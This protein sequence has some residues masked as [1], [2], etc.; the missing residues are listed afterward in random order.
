MQ[1]TALQASERLDQISQKL[2]VPEF[3]AICGIAETSLSKRKSHLPPLNFAFDFSEK[4]CNLADILETPDFPN[5]ENHYTKVFSFSNPAV[6]LGFKAAV[7]HSVKY[8]KDEKD[9]LYDVPEDDLHF[10]REYAFL[11][12]L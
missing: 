9:Q 3:H 12:F 1:I 5:D 10:F 4:I 11:A 7:A 2:M 8:L 6:L